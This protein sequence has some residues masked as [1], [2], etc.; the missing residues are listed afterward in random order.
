MAEKN[1]CQYCV[2]YVFDDEEECYGCAVSMDED[3]M[4]R[5]FRGFLGGCPYF[6]YSDDYKIAAKQ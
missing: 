5:S 3:D 2:N 4:E 6:H 1:Q